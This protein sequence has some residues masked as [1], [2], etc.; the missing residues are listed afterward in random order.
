[1]RVQTINV[2][3]INSD[4]ELVREAFDFRGIPQSIYVK[5]GRTYYMNWAQIGINRILEFIE[6]YEAIAEDAYQTLQP[7]PNRIT[8]Y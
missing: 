8:I 6:R 5:D 4:D 1:V 3:V 2:G 7:A